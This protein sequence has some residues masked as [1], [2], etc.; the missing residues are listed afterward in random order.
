MGEHYSAADLLVH[1]PYAWFQD[2][3]PDDPLI[4][5]WIARCMA[6]PARLRALHRDEALMAN[7]A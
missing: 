5:D 1:S 3:T 6:R 4:R 2:A 7:A